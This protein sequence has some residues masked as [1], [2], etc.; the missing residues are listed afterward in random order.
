M[1]KILFIALAIAFA[2]C[3]KCYQCTTT[4][5]SIRSDGTISG[6]SV[7]ETNFCG[8]AREKTKHEKESSSTVPGSFYSKT[9]T[10]MECV[11][12]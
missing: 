9:V 1:K 10:V 11:L 2:S 4:K 7:T 8:T 3:Q 5:T 6:Q 12:D